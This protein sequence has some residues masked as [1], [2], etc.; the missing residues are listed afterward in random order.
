MPRLRFPGFEGEW[1][2]INLSD[3]AT[4]FE[5]GL[6]VAAT[7]YDGEHK[8]IRITDINDESHK[9]ISDFPVSPSGMIDEH[10]KVNKNDIL[11][12]RT[13]ASVGKTYLY[14]SEDG[15]LYYA[16]FL[17][18]INVI[19]ASSFFVYS[20]TLTTRYY[21][22]VT[23]TSMRSGQPGIN[24]REYAS[25]SFYIPTIN[26]QRKISSFLKLIDKRI[27]K[28]RQFIDAL[29][30]YKRG[31][32]SRLF[33]KNG[34]SVPEYRF[35]GFTG[36]WEQRKLGDFGNATGGTAIESEFSEDGIYKVISIGS[37]S[38]NN[39]YQDQGIRAI[40]SDK[41]K[42]QILNQGDLTM[43]L[44]DK[45]VS[46]NIIGRVLLIEKSGV[47]VYNQRTER[48]EVDSENYDSLFVYE[49]L[50]APQI[51]DKI[52]KQ[53]QGNTQIYVNW[54]SIALTEYFVPQIEEQRKIGIYLKNL[55][56]LITLHQRKL[57]EYKSI[58][59]GLLEKL[60]I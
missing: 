50:N 46:G 4:G 16:G 58:K 28:Q 48:I 13:G 29:K 34:A 44:N 19:N 57:D 37:Y 24:A 53:S 35:S 51:R 36:N 39:S 31:A 21:R 54:S 12:A 23:N 45:T 49:M 18:R 1:E 8:Y 17:I 32:L 38:E 43:I 52:I 6:N 9:Y 42:N 27:D 59:K 3:V 2:L 41:I 47:Y 22:W 33:P 60:F 10:Y 30:L 56:T 5:Y 14:N 26:E 25:Y 7:E 15:Q 40:D 55:D 11:F 20:Q